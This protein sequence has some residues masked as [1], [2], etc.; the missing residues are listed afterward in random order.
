MGYLFW[1]IMV[2][3]KISNIEV[4]KDHILVTVN[5]K[6]YP[7][8]V[9]YSAA[10]VLLDKAYVVIDGDPDKKVIVEIRPKEKYD[11]IKLGN[12]FNNELI[13]YAVYKVQ[14][15]KNRAIREAFIQRALLTNV[16]TQKEE[17]YIDDPEGIAVP[18]EEKYGKK[19]DK[20]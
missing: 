1:G 9:L 18:W 19:D 14:S 10:Y 7:L 5:P 3:N 16:A 15:E 13:N 17:D 8:D 2:K 20:C 6:V 12:E 4:Y 11:L